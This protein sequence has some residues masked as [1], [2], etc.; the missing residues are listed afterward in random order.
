MTT[1]LYEYSFEHNH[2]APTICRDI[3]VIS[4]ET[5]AEFDRGQTSANIKIRTNINIYKPSVGKVFT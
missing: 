2:F 4:S 3:L 1:I 5:M